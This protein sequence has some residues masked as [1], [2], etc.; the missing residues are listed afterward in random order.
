VRRV[1]D[2]TVALGV[3]VLLSGVALVVLAVLTQAARP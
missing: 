3:G 1:L 2:W